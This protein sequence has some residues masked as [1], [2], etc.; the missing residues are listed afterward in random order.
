MSDLLN[1]FDRRKFREKISLSAEHCPNYV[2]KECIAGDQIVFTVNI[3]N[4]HLRSCMILSPSY[5]FFLLYF[6]RAVSNK[7]TDEREF[8]CK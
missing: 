1:S 5:S 7:T 8:S 2:K 6:L 3:P 4:E